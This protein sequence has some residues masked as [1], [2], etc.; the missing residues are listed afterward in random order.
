MTWIQPN[1]RDEGVLLRKARSEYVSYPESMQYGSFR[2][3][4]TALDVQVA[5]TV[6]SRVV[7]TFLQWHPDATDVPLLNGMRIQIVPS[8]G[9]LARARKHQF[10][11]FLAEEL[12]LVVWDDDPLNVIARAKGIEN[13]LMQLV[14]SSGEKTEGEEGGDLEDPEA[15]GQGEKRSTNLQNTVLVAMTLFLITLLLGLGYRQIAIQTKVDGNYMRVMFIVLTP[16]QI[17]FTLVSIFGGK[18]TGC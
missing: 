12:L 15:G 7:K 3:A 8:M 4:C 18:L 6:N 11:A 1:A 16:V 17:F 5:M 14:W 2:D 10:A 13:E 9:E